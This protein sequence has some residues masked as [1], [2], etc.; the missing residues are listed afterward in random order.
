VTISGELDDQ[1]G[2]GRAAQEVTIT[3]TG[4]NNPVATKVITAADGTFSFTTTDASTSTTSLVDTVTFAA[5]GA[6]SASVTINYANTAV[7]TITVTGGNT[8]ASVTSLV[9]Q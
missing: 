6:T 5:G 1:Y 3:T 7:G 2:I 9:Q 8:T 4:R